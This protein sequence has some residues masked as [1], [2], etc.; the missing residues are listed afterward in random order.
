MVNKN[1][2]QSQRVSKRKLAEEDQ[3]VDSFILDV[4]AQL[5]Y[6]QDETRSLS[7]LGVQLQLEILKEMRRRRMFL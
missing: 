2:I 1:E 4:E 3:R 6:L 7:Y 5:E